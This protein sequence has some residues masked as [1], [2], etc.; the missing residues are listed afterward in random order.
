MHV[1]TI[2]NIN[3]SKIVKKQKVVSLLGDY[4]LASSNGPA[5]TVSHQMVSGTQGLES[6]FA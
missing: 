4:L 1:S 3:L 2:K 5:L 6:L